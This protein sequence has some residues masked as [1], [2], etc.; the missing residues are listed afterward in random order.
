MSD[1]NE[2][3]IENILKKAYENIL[4]SKNDYFSYFAKESVSFELWFTTELA[5]FLKQQDCEVMF[6]PSAM[7][8]EK[9]K[10]IENE[11]STT[12]S[13]KYLD[14]FV[15]K[16]KEQCA[17]EIKIATPAT[18]DKYKNNCKSDMDKL[19]SLANVLSTNQIYNTNEIKKLFILVTA[20]EKNRNIYNNG[21]SKWLNEIFSDDA[22]SFIAYSQFA[23]ESKLDSE[24][25]HNTTVV[26][27]QHVIN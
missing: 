24:E 1:S 11:T 6:T 18:Q 9:I 22:A 25:T 12:Y 19:T 26:V 23:G 7:I 14:L 5:M 20:S 10:N 17:I 21:W 15:L 13:Y 3:C 4:T 27:Y 2:S 8:R 16:E